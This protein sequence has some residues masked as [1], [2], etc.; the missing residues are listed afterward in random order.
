MKELHK[1]AAR[2]AKRAVR[3]REREA[4]GQWAVVRLSG[5]RPCAGRRKKGIERKRERKL[6]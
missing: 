2:R 3:A 5:H 6:D 4:T 1:R